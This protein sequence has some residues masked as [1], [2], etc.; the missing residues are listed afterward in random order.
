MVLDGRHTTGIDSCLALTQQF[1]AAVAAYLWL[2]AEGVIQTILGYV[3]AES[4]VYSVATPMTG[5]GNLQE[6]G[7]Q[8]PHL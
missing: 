8:R 3:L 2:C 1:P 4:H 7:R 6:A 5:R